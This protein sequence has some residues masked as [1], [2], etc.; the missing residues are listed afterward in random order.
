MATCHDPSLFATRSCDGP[1]SFHEV[2]EEE[3]MRSTGKGRLEDQTTHVAHRGDS[4]QNGGL[5][6][7]E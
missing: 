4:E 3:E 2:D 6:L 5:L 7:Q 1:E